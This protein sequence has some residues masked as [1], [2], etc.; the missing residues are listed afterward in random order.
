MLLIAA[1][2]RLSRYFLVAN[3]KSRTSNDDVILTTEKDVTPMNPQREFKPKLLLPAVLSAIFL[4]SAAV[5]AALY[6]YS[7]PP[8]GSYKLEIAKA[9]LQL[10]VVSILGTGV[11]ILVFKY[12]SERQQFDRDREHE[13]A[14][15]EHEQERQRK[16]IEYREDLLKATLAK[17]MASY[18]SVKKA[19]RLLRARAIIVQDSA[20]YVWLDPYDTYIDIINESQLDFE[21]LVRDVE[22]SEPAFSSPRELIQALRT[23]ERFL[24]K[25]LKEYETFRRDFHGDVPRKKLNEFNEL[26]AFIGPF[27]G[28]RF[29]TDFVGPYHEIQRAIRGDLLH[30]QLSGIR[31]HTS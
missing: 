14:L 2:K 24:G 4:V 3:S 8:A 13:R 23:M 19:R 5:L 28:S 6:F 29:A 16:H 11:S 27:E 26:R 31:K 18:N 9:I 17:T 1:K 25:M 30:P 20:D 22:M 15:A 10:G 12:Q 7:P 21:N